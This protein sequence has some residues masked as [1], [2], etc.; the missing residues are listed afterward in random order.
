MLE[1]NNQNNQSKFNKLGNEWEREMNSYRAT[2]EKLKIENQELK[3]YKNQI[4]NRLKISTEQL[5]KKQTKV[6]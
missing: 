6:K 2:L 3:S 4:E 1:A 5:E